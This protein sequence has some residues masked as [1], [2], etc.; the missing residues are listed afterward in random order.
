MLSPLSISSPMANAPVVITPEDGKFMY[1]FIANNG[2]MF[3]DENWFKLK[4]LI[5]ESK[6]VEEIEQEMIKESFRKLDLRRYT[7]AS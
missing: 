1:F 5:R 7:I 6:S 2:T 3:F 4:S